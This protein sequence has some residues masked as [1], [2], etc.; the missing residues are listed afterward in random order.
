MLIMYSGRLKKIMCTENE[1]EEEGEIVEKK[2]RIETTILNEKTSQHVLTSTVNVPSEGIVLG[3]FVSTMFDD[4]IIFPEFEIV[5]N[6]NEMNE[7]SDD[8]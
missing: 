3:D 5:E 1:D 4:D 2:K 7:L 6:A 8:D